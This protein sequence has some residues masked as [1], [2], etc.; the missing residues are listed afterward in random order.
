MDRHHKLRRDPNWSPH[1]CNL[2]GKEGHQA[3][4][5]TTGTVDWI[6]RFGLDHFLP[7]KPYFDI[8][9]REKPDYGK[10][11]EAARLYAE[12]KELATKNVDTKGASEKFK[13]ELER[14]EQLKQSGEGESDLPVGWKA[15]TA[16][17]G[18]K[19]YHNLATNK[20][21]WKKPEPEGTAQA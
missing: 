7:K 18:K 11:E 6:D 21:Q 12:A 10:V 8:K 2:C 20:T 16:P 9:P 17:N 14:Q 3:A 5:C 13:E 4:Q 19:Y 15:Y 1:G